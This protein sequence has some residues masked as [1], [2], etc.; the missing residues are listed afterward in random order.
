GG[1]N[2]RLLI[3]KAKRMR[4]NPT[5][6]EKVLWENLRS[7][8]IGY[9]FRQQHLIDDF[10]VDFVCLSKKLVIEVDGEIHDSRKEQDLERTSILSDR[11]FRVIRF[12]NAKVLTDLDNVLDTIKQE[13][14][15]SIVP[16]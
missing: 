3:E 9:K 2:A 10:I 15:N 11:G 16:P 1:N 13:L 7:K 12:S 4:E 14:E 5:E 6:A 8:K